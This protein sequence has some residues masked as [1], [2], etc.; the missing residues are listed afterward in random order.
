MA[1]LYVVAARLIMQVGEVVMDLADLP[2]TD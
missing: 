1:V 2:N